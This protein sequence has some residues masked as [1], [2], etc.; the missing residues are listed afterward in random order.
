MCVSGH[1]RYPNT[2]K[3]TFSWHVLSKLKVTLSV[4]LKI[5]LALMLGLWY[6]SADLMIKNKNHNPFTLTSSLYLKFHSQIKHNFHSICCQGRLT[7]LSWL[8]S[9]ARKSL[10]FCLYLLDCDTFVLALYCSGK[11]LRV[12]PVLR[13]GTV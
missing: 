13:I 9:F 11:Y 1:S 5:C 7:V 8:C 10:N 6:K 3:V 2:E 12:S 4:A